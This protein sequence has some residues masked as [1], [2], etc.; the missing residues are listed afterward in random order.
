M[1]RQY[2]AASARLIEYDDQRKAAQEAAL[3][4]A[5]KPKPASQTLKRARNQD[6]SRVPLTNTPAT[7]HSTGNRKDVEAPGCSRYLQGLLKKRE[8]TKRLNR[9]AAKKKNRPKRTK[10]WISLPSKGSSMFGGVKYS[11]VRVWQGGPPGLGK[12]R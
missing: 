10:F 3:K 4:K 2:E 5:A 6:G 11:Y 12:R 1:E 9:E 7:I 8:A